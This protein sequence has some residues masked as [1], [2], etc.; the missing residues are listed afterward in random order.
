MRQANGIDDI[1]RPGDMTG[2]SIASDTVVGRDM[3]VE[4]AAR[5]MRGRLSE[6]YGAGEAEAMVRLIFHHLKGW[7]AAQ[8]FMH[9]GDVL[10][11][12][13]TSKISGFMRRIIDEAEPIQYVLGEGR[14]YGMDLK[15]T[16][17]VLV[18]RP[19]TAELVD[20]VVDRYGETPDL[21]VLD[22]CTGS[23]AIAIALARNLRFPDVTA[24]DV[25]AAALDVARENARKL[26]A[27]VEFVEADLMKWMPDRESLDI[28][29]SNPPYVDESE[30]ASMDA[31]VLKWEP[32]MAL[33][34]PDA[35][36]LV[37][38]RRIAEIGAEGLKRGGEMYM[39]INPRHADELKAM[40]E[41][42][43]F[44]DVEIRNDSFGKRRFAVCGKA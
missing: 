10:S 19:E 34:V 6:R 27:G 25:S 37:F 28:I 4:D 39:E 13:M 3:R 30:R 24:L 22:A 2:N 21:Q 5:A 17:A 32:E 42:R 43:G 33:F 8:L 15:V 31:N 36:P 26:R 18:P 12:Y 7:S 40:L 1:D 16:P 41:G 38:Y 44:T 9:G 23:G 14:F 20:M 29:V 11:D 35:D